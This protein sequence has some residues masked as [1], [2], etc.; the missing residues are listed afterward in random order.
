VNEGTSTYLL[1]ELDGATITKPIARRRLKPVPPF[2]PIVAATGS[3]TYGPE[4]DEAF[5][6]LP[7]IDEEERAEY[8][9][10]MP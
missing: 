10:V 2:R 7:S 5:V 1:E 3:G 8:K 4:E 6:D 9:F